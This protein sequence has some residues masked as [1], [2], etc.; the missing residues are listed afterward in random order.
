M[1][2]ETFNL[3]GCVTDWHPIMIGVLMNSFSFILGFFLNLVLMQSR[4]VS[5]AVCRA[6]REN[7]HALALASASGNTQRL[8]RIEKDM[9]KLQ[10]SVQ[11]NYRTMV[12]IATKL[13][14]EIHE[15]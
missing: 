14:V 2:G 12:A 10:E 4:F 13:K 11:A 1:S 6:A 9:T 15:G 3:G 7:C 8:E 5:V